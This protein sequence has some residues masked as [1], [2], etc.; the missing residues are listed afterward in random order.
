[1][2]LSV[3]VA[4]PVCA[5]NLAVAQHFGTFWRVRTDGNIGL[6][7]LLRTYVRVRIVEPMELLDRQTDRQTELPAVMHFHF[8]Q[9]VTD[10]RHFVICQGHGRLIDEAVLLGVPGA[11]T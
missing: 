2:R 6:K 3:P 9:S 8:T 10:S 4:R 5:V 11:D 1:V 7:W